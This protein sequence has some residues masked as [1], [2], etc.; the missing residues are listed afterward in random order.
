MT[1]FAVWGVISV[2][3]AATVVAGHVTEAITG[4]EP[5]AG[6]VALVTLGLTLWFGFSV[7][8]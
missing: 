8:F 4:S 5:A 3:S 6:L 1:F 7:I 2:A